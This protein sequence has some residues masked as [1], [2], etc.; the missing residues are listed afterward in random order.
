MVEKLAYKTISTENK[1]FKLKYSIK[2]CCLN[3]LL[4]IHKEVWNLELQQTT[5]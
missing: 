3:C 5:T 1:L 2:I 4:C